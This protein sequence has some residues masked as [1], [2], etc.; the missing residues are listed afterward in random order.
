MYFSKCTI[1]PTE[2][3]QFYSPQHVWVRHIATTPAAG[4]PDH[5]T[6]LGNVAIPSPST[7]CLTSEGTPACTSVTKSPPLITF[8]VALPRTL[9]DTLCSFVQSRIGFT[10]VKHLISML[11]CSVTVIK[12]TLN[13]EAGAL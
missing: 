8:S 13:K 12:D 10:N 6:F 5:V 4:V 7:A 3:S 11:D 2:M 9:G 1:P